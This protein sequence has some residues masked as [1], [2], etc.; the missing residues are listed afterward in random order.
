MATNIDAL[1]S[2]VGAL[3]IAPKSTLFP[4][5][6]ETP[7]VPWSFLGE[8]YDGVQVETGETINTRRLDGHTGKAKAIRSEETAIIR[9]KLAEMT[10]E[11]LA[12]IMGTSVIDTPAAAGVP[13]TRKIPLYRGRAVTEYALL[14]RGDSPYGAGFKAQYQVTRGY[15]KMT[16]AVE[17]KDDDFAMLSVEFEALED[18]DAA[19]TDRFG[20]WV[21]Q[22]A[23]A[24]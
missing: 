11:N 2:G 7:A 9:T 12:R 8:T 18:L 13:G 5:I 14:F 10:A 4:E 21:G 15:L 20:H 22:D 1:L 23:S 3:Y 17:Y 16:G 24:L 6:D 19:E